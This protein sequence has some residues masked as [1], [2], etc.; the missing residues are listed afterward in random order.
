MAIYLVR[1]AIRQDRKD[2]D[3]PNR[4]DRPHDT[5]LSKE[6]FLQA[7]FLGKRLAEEPIKHIFSSPFLRAIQ[8]AHL[9]AQEIG[10]Q[11][12]IEHGFA[13]YMRKRWFPTFE[14]LPTYLAPED[15][16]RHYHTIDT[17]YKSFWKLEFPEGSQQLI[18][19][20]RATTFEL[21]DK[22]GDNLLF[23]GHGFSVKRSAQALVGYDKHIRSACAAL[24]K[25]E[26]IDEDWELVL[27]N[28]RSYLKP[29]NAFLSGL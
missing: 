28:D 11:V 1:H 5:P 6:G 13:E 9:I 10:L 20:T 16:I 26:E 21:I 12:K 24:T 29:V 14:T 7:I 2:K 17:S 8:T 27:N 3:W 18:D 25:I 23:V 19:R 22:F 15:L 4:T